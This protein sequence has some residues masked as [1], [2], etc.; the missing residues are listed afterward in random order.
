MILFHESIFITKDITKV[1]IN[2]KYSSFSYTLYSIHFY[3]YLSTIFYRIRIF[4]PDNTWQLNS[5]YEEENNILFHSMIECVEYYGAD[6]DSIFII[7][8]GLNRKFGRSKKENC[9]LNFINK[10]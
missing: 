2:K 6:E 8:K 4:R 10:L 1:R 5:L 3:I 9:V 7:G